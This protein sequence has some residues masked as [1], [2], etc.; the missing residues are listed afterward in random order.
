MIIAFL[1][2]VVAAECKEEG[3]TDQT[4]DERGML[5][6]VKNFTR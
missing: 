4:T 5:H 1:Q 6:A 3:D 2:P